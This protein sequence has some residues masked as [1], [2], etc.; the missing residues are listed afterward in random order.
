MNVHWTHYSIN[1]NIVNELYLE[2]FLS[3]MFSVSNF[4]FLIYLECFVGKMYDIFNYFRCK[5]TTQ[6]LFF[7]LRFSTHTHEYQVYF[8][9]AIFK[10]NVNFLIF[11]VFCYYLL[12]IFISVYQKFNNN[13]VYYIKTLVN[14][15]YILHFN[16]HLWVFCFSGFDF[17]NKIEVFI[18]IRFMTNFISTIF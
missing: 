1:V 17:K 5:N 6:N 11:L 12:K 4:Y 3:I 18:I 15:H 13:T 8:V 2:I 9:M 14:L 7:A 16:L 10:L